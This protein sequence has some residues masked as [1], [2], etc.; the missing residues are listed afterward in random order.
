MVARQSL[1]LIALCIICQINEARSLQVMLKTQNW[2]CFGFPADFKTILDIDY[3]I[4][5][6]SPEDVSFEAVQNGKQIKTMGDKRSAEVRI[7]SQGLEQI[8]LCWKKRDTKS[9]KLDFSVSRNIAHS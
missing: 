8:D 4:T 7:E 1:L 2:Y 3:L 5:G 9:K 6:I